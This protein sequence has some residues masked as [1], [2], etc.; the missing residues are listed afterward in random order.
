MRIAIMG[1]GGVGG[2]FGARLA[3]AGEDVRFIARGAHLAAMQA[4]GLRV[5]SAVGDV[6]IAPVTVESD[7]ACIGP[8]DLVLF[9]VKLWDTETAAAAC[10]PLLDPAT[11]VIPFQNGVTACG[12]L[13][14][15]LGAQH[16]MGGVAYIAAVI[17]EP[18]RIAHTGTMARLRFGELD[19]SMS[20]RALAFDAA[21]K[22]AGID[23]AA[24]DEIEALI[25][26]KFVFLT[27]L[28]GITCLARLPIGPLRADPDTRATLHA[29]MHE[30]WQVARAEGV[31]L[32]EAFLDEQM[33]FADS[34][35]ASMQ[36][37]MLHDLEQGNRLEA[38]WLCGRVVELARRHGIAAPVNSTIYSALKLHNAGR[39]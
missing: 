24:T 2:Y 23:G 15:V 18:G 35:P 7:P 1:S 32:T 13:K 26:R 8:V 29:I 31:A 11:A 30:T 5:S 19:G 10:K 37:S 9:C 25:W 38:P 36:A 21:C 28:S 33:A 20:A 27:G 17:G 14:N 16:V 12:I 3:A 4:S 22:R 39:K 34:L 6:H